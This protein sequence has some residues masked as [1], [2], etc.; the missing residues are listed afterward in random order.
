MQ[1]LDPSSQRIFDAL[2]R[3]ICELVPELSAAA[4]G[5]EDTLASLGLN[6]IDRTEAI[7]LTLEALALDVPIHEFRRGDTLRGL[8]AVMRRYA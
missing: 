4:I 8:V 5:P 7:L 3:N 1:P 6:S 2:R